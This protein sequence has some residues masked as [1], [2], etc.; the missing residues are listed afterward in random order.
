MAVLNPHEVELHHRLRCGWAAFHKHNAELCCKAYR[1]EDRARLFDCVVTPVVLYGCA[2]WALQKDQERQMVTTWRRM[3][4]YVLN[5]HRCRAVGPDESLLDGVAYVQR[6]A[7]ADNN[8]ASKLEMESWLHAQK[9]RKWRSARKTMT[10][11]DGRWTKK[12]IQWIP[13][14]GMERDRSRSKARWSDQLERYAGGHWMDIAKD[15]S[16]WKILEEGFVSI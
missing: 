6:S 16:H 1:P 2:L 5:I 15:Q 11:G 10:S 4:R 9:R 8:L 14:F 13:S 3:L 7:H 12:T